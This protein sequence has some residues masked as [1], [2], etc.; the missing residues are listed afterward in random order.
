MKLHNEAGMTITSEK[1]ESVSDDGKVESLGQ[2]ATD[3]NLERP[4]WLPDLQLLT[5]VEVAQILGVSRSKVYELLY[6]RALKSVKIGGSRRIRYSDL[7]DYVRYLD[8]E[9]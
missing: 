3:E 2:V 4:L 9:S 5:V 6:S 1:L 8:D 7:G